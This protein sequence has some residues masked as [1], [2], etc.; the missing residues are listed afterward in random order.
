MGTVK[1]LA[2]EVRRG[3]AGVL[4]QLR[5]TVVKKLALAVGATIGGQT[6][7]TAGLAHL[8]PLKTGRQDMREQWP[9]RLPKN[10]LPPAT[11]VMGPF[12]REELARAARNGQTVLPGMDRP[13]PGGRMAAPGHAARRS[14]GPMFPDFKGR[15]FDLGD[16]QLEHAGRLERLILVMSLAMHWR[17]RVGRDDALN[18]PTPPEKKH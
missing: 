11:A 17:V 5:K 15:G 3:L 10:P 4:P 7:N 9:G 16:S 6:P 13:G 18:S 2:E 8:L 12:A 1:K 14:I